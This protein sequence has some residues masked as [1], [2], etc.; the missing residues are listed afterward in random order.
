MTINTPIANEAKG[1]VSSLDPSIASGRCGHIKPLSVL[2]FVITSN[3]S[4]FNKGLM[5][6]MEGS[7]RL[8]QN[9]GLRSI[10]ERIYHTDTEAIAV[11]KHGH[12]KDAERRLRRALRSRIPYAKEVGLRMFLREKEDE[13]I[14]EKSSVSSE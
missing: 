12:E 8:S 9:H 2:E 6:A 11:I 5:K 13:P 4:K 3:D 7:D 14:E 10:F 1:P